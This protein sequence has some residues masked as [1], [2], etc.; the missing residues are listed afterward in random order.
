MIIPY[1]EYTIY[2]ITWYDHKVTDRQ[3]FVYVV[4]E[5]SVSGGLEV[6]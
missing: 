6:R 2:D 4:I 3:L 5:Y 1:S